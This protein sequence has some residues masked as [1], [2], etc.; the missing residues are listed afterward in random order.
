MCFHATFQQLFSASSE[1]TTKQC[2]VNTKYTLKR[3]H[4]L[5]MF[6]RTLRSKSCKFP[7]SLTQTSFVCDEEISRPVFPAETRYYCEHSNENTIFLEKQLQ[8]LI[9]LYCSIEK[10]STDRRTKT[11]RLRGF[12]KV[13]PASPDKR[14]PSQLKWWSKWEAT[15]RYGKKQSRKPFE[16]QQQK[17]DWGVHDFQVTFIK[18]KIQSIDPSKIRWNNPT[19]KRRVQMEGDQQMVR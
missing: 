3:Q 5:A 14:I 12:V 16:K 7:G 17:S 13:I 1:Y 19:I 8:L 9:Q 18:G 4:W 15:K 10:S 11:R 2:S 6:V